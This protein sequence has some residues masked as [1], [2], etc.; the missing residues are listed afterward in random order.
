MTNEG[1]SKAHGSV[2]SGRGPGLVR[3]LD[4]VIAGALVLGALSGC[5]L[6]CAPSGSL[7]LEVDGHISGGVLGISCEE[8]NANHDKVN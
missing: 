6:R 1:H 5:A 7:F 4:V 8:V 2:W 3:H